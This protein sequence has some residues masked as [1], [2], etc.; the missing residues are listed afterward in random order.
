LKRQ[1]E[2]TNNEIKASKKMGYNIGIKL[3]RGAYMNEE[4]SLAEK[5]GQESPVHESLEE[6][7]TGYN[8]CMTK[9]IENMNDNGLLIVASHNI[10][11]V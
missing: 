7:H 6:T 5:H 2:A 1:P 9:I 3:V 11:S 8:Y 4:R 10:G